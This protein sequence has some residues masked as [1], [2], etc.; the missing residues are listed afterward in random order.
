MANITPTVLTDTLYG[1]AYAVRW[2]NMLNGDV[3][4]GI[5][6]VDL[7][8]RTVMATDRSIQVE[9][10]AGAG[11]TLVIEGTNMAVDP[12]G[13]TPLFETL[14]DALG[15]SLSFAA[16]GSIKSILEATY[17]IRPR[18]SAGD[19]TTSVTVTLFAKGIV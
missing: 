19:G 12:A 5:N 6:G 3:G 2:A 9:G 10:T 1:H 13:T 17:A 4:L 15:N 14:R 11:L 16:T 8:H 18:V 7:A